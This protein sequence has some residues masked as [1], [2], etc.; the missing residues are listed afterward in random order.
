MFR[1]SLFNYACVFLF[2][3]CIYTSLDLCFFINHNLHVIWILMPNGVLSS[4]T[5][6]IS[7]SF[8]DAAM[9]RLT[10][11]TKVL[12]EG[13]YDKV[14]RQIFETSP[15][16][17]LLHSYACYLSTS[18]GPV[19]GTLY[20]SNKRIAFCSDVPLSHYSSYGNQE[21]IYYKVCFFYLFNSF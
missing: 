14:F 11:G 12:T 15:G 18:T 4:V 19:I 17:K 13:G 7:P 20:I 9:A 3:F 1:S 6:K 5:V 10:Q 21:W 16:E 2:D 8:T